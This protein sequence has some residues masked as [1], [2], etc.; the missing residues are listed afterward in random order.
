M[1][2][3]YSYCI[4]TPSSQVLIHHY[5]LSII[6]ICFRYGPVNTL[7]LITVHGIVYM[8]HLTNYTIIKY[9]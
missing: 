2:S 1:V 8:G 7:A 6:A 5:K 9:L 4:V 3:A